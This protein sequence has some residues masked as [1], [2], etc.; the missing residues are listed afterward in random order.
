MI[1][2][3]PAHSIGSRTFHNSL[4]LE[5][6]RR[7]P[8]VPTGRALHLIDIDALVHAS[9]GHSLSVM[10]QDAW[11][12]FQIREHDHI[13]ASSSITHAFD[14][15]QCM[16]ES[17]LLILSPSET[18]AER[19]R[20]ELR[21]PVWI[22]DR[23]DRMT[24]SSRDIHCADEVSAIQRLGVAVETLE[25]GAGADDLARSWDAISMSPEIAKAA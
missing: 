19:L 18:G 23:Y 5:K 9:G 13:I 16:P 6:R 4:A 22:A 20:A 17:R 3:I 2:R 21:N 12:R 25:L 1:I 7:S 11:Q 15:L 24:C 8:H 14:V 10:L